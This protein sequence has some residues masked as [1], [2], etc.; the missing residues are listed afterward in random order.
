MK[1]EMLL[2]TSD[3]E[4]VSA[5]RPGLERLGIVV[6]LR[7]ETLSASE[8]CNRRRFDGVILDTDIGAKS[9]DL[10]TGI[11][12]G[13]ANHLSSL[14]A[15]TSDMNTDELL[16]LGA[17]FALTKPLCPE[18]FDQY[19]QLALSAMAREHRRYFRFP[20]H[21]QATVSRVSDTYE[22]KII[23]VSEGG[24]A[25]QG[26]AGDSQGEKLKLS[27]EVPGGRLEIVGQ[28]V[29]ADASGAM[30]VQFAQYDYESFRLFRA[31]VDLLAAG[32]QEDGLPTDVALIV[33]RLVH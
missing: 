20:V 3:R 16:R 32:E 4:V 25:L 30:G 26:R 23:N 15:V 19:L 29:W 17:N 9:S 28:I 14:I 8:V 5:V 18:K 24:L 7:A 12:R 13:R 1:L 31:W 33:P 21:L 11:R 27:F 10:L 6:Q 2:V 22:G